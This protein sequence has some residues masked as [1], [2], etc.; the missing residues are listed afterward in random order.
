VTP[1]LDDATGAERRNAH[2]ERGRQP[3]ATVAIEERRQWSL[4]LV[5]V[6]VVHD[7]RRIVIKPNDEAHA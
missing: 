2:G 3:P 4:L 6:R 7:R 5:R 1:H